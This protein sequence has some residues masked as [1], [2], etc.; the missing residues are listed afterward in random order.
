MD[1]EEFCCAICLE[2]LYK[3]AVSHCGHCFCF[4]C[5]HHGMSNLGSSHCPLCRAELR[6]LPA[7][8]EPLHA[9]ICATFPARAAERAA[10]TKL[11]ERQS[12]H[13][14]APEPRP[15]A[16]A[17]TAASF[18]CAGCGGLAAPPA[19]L[20]CGHVV[21]ARRGGGGCP[22]DGCVGQAPEG[23]LAPCG[24][25]DAILRKE[26]S[27]EEYAAASACGCERVR[28]ERGGPPAEALV[29][30]EVQLRSLRTEDGRAV[31]GVTGVVVGEEAGE[32]VVEVSVESREV[33]VPAEHVSL[34]EAAR[35]AE[36]S[37]VHFG[38][39]CDGCGVY[40]VVGRC[41]RCA[42]CS[43]AIGYDLCGSCYDAGVHTRDAPSGRF[44][45]A[46]KP[47]HNL[48]EVRQVVTVVHQLQRAHPELSLEQIVTLVN[49][50]VAE[51]QN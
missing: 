25:I 2:T 23:G 5:F 17:G 35:S 12:W 42:D 37:Y 19:V 36:E 33:R 22:V 26:L 21:H 8:C 4:W 44:N 40:P 9:Y 41:Y 24:L 39:G 27:A 13:A 51:H 15:L 16:G 30:R 14:E 10:A 48:V 6:H 29:G 7:I 45:Q 46:H 47:E 34:V 50:H 28:R 11:E 31:E 32:L 20:T 38:R 49:A 18:A 1:L 43:E 3:P